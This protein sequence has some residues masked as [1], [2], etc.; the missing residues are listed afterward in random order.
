MVSSINTSTPV[1]TIAQ[2][3][4]SKQTE[5]TTAEQKSTAVIQQ[6]TA[7]T[8]TEKGSAALPQDLLSDEVKKVLQSTSEKT[9]S[10]SAK[11]TS[12]DNGPAPGEVDGSESESSSAASASDSGPAPGAVDSDATSSKKTATYDSRDTN[13][14]GKVSTN[15]LLTASAN[16]KKQAENL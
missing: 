11:A 5:A 16:K 4:Q 12:S 13:K 3:L 10:G 8:A 15:E 2:G 14:D 7:V 6:K 9:S 1:Q